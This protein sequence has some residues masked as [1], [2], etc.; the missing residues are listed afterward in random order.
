MADTQIIS[1]DTLDALRYVKDADD[2]RAFSF[3]LSRTN[4]DEFESCI[5]KMTESIVGFRLSSLNY[6]KQIAGRI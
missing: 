1:P 5:E 3:A 2:K 4:L 6:L